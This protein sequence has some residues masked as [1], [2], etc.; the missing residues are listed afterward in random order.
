MDELS[1]IKHTTGDRLLITTTYVGF[2]AG[3]IAGTSTCPPGPTG[4]FMT[5]QESDTQALRAID[6][7]QFN[8][9]D[10]TLPFTKF[11]FFWN[12]VLIIGIEFKR[13]PFSAIF[14]GINNDEG[15]HR[16][17]R[18][19]WIEND[20]YRRN[21]LKDAR[22]P[23]R[24]IN[25]YD[26]HTRRSVTTRVGLSDVTYVNAPKYE[27]PPW[28]CPIHSDVAW[29]DKPAIN[30]S[31][32]EWFIAGVLDRIVLP[33]PPP[34]AEVAAPVDVAPAKEKA[35]SEAVKNIFSDSEY[36]EK[37][38]GEYEKTYKALQNK[39]KKP[40]EYGNLSERVIDL[41]SKRKAILDEQK[42]RVELLNRICKIILLMNNSEP[43]LD[44]YELWIEMMKKTMSVDVPNIPL[45]RT[46]DSR[47]LDFDD[48]GDIRDD[49]D[50]ATKAFRRT[51]S[52]W[53]S[54]RG[55]SQGSSQGSSSYR[56]PEKKTKL[57]WWTATETYES[58]YGSIPIEDE[59]GLCRAN[60]DEIKD[61]L[62]RLYHS[63]TVEEVKS[64]LN[65][66]QL[67]FLHPDKNLGCIAL[68][69]AVFQ[70]VGQLKDNISES[71]P[72]AA[73]GRRRRRS[74]RTR[75][76]SRK[77]HTGRRKSRR[78]KRRTSRK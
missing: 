49:D 31:E 3:S 57:P 9:N 43:L 53:W 11:G 39:D 35:A 55:S 69:K 58:K 4:L 37:E 74:K 12:G 46:K 7:G 16:L 32:L 60:T 47:P 8:P 26:T 56:R 44:F 28:F 77:V 67:R 21:A 76:K 71:F 61:K 66:R 22:L 65:S 48:V 20:V 59:N 42:Y 52:E 70:D 30:V 18:W 62:N 45:F 38:L 2:D 23:R 29:V 63:T 68:S 13:P 33:S 6:S 17:G 72:S 41:R 24:E 27:T 14:C 19:T 1:V 5:F 51:R 64:L 10:P 78:N 15:H 34:A 36:M 40:N 73:G 54:S 50:D 75:R 25:L